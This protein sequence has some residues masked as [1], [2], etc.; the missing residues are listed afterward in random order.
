MK[1]YYENNDEYSLFI[2]ISINK[3]EYDFVLELKTIEL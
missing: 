1:L 3:K 2:T